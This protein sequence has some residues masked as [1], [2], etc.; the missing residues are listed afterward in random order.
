MLAGV[1]DVTYALT[2]NGVRGVGGRLLVVGIGYLVGGLFGAVVAMAAI[3]ALETEPPGTVAWTAAATLVAAAAATVLQRWPNDH[4]DSSFATD[5]SLAAALGQAAAILAFIAVVWAARAERSAPRPHERVRRP[6]LP[7]TRV[8]VGTAALVGTVG[9]VAWV[10]RVVFAPAAMPPGYSG[11]VEALQ[12]G[13]GFITAARPPLAAV[14]AALAPV[15]PDLLIVAV[16]GATVAVVAVLAGRVGGRRTAVVAGLLAAVLPSVWGQQLPEALAALGVAGALS[17][18]WP[19]RLS[20]GRAVLAGLAMAA[21]TLARPE[22]A[23]LV[24]VVLLWLFAARPTERRGHWRGEAL[25]AVVL[26]AF[27]VGYAPWATWVASEHGT[28]LPSTNLGATLAGANTAN[29]QR[30]PAVGAWDQRGVF[31]VR[32]RA[33]LD[34]TARD[35]A[36]RSAAWQRADKTRALGIAVTRVLRGW[37]LWSPTNARTARADRGLPFPGG[38]VG[39]AGEMAVTLLAVAGIAARRRD[40]RTL[41]PFLALPALFSLE[42]ALLFG[43]RGLRGWVAPVVVVLASVALTRSRAVERESEPA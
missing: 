31:D 42:S 26:A 24:P 21:A 17:W 10:V 38:V 41:L 30:G 13:D 3:V 19:D 34:E 22:A 5:R 35:K 43:D 40:W 37:D 39:A 9:L 18:A 27:V 29:T 20:P 15:A 14:V 16:T 12:A 36:L 6:A 1:R 25:A 28:F 23:L 11:S 7:I 32:L 8:H 2:R 33:G 4:V